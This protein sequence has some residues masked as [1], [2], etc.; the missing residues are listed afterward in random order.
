MFMED[1]VSL[2]FTFYMV[3]IYFPYTLRGISGTCMWIFE[4]MEM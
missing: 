2:I 3:S 1:G 4:Y